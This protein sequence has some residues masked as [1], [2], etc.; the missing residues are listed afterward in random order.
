MI[1]KNHYHERIQRATHQ[2]AQLQARELLAS[3]REAAKAKTERRREEIRRR[4]RVAEIVF[5][6]GAGSLEDDELLGALLLYSECRQTTSQKPRSAALP[7]S[8]PS[9]PELLHLKIC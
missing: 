6:A 4:Q 3:Q 8:P 2:L 9:K 5:L 7:P 1:K